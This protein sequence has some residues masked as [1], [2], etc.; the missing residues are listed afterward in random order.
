[1]CQGL[2]RKLLVGNG[3]TQCDTQ[4]F[5]GHI[6]HI[7]CMDLVPQDGVDETEGSF[8]L[9]DREG[10]NLSDFKHTRNVPL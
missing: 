4:W 3:S 1:M 2:L 5:L 6:S 10:Y 9:L 8:L 7:S